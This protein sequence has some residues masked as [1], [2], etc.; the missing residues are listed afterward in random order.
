MKTLEHHRLLF[1]SSKYERFVTEKFQEVANSKGAA[2][3]VA[4]TSDTGHDVANANED[5][6]GNTVERMPESVA[7]DNGKTG[8]GAEAPGHSA[9]FGI[10][11]ICVCGATWAVQNY[12]KGKHHPRQFR[13]P[14]EKNVGQCQS[15]PTRCPRHGI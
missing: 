2:V 12:K 9:F 3:T 4:A 10:T 13:S 14:A 5:E 1:F 15:L 7:G 6:D 11:L 8:G